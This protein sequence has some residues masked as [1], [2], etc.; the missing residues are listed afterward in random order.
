MHA[1]KSLMK[2]LFY[3]MNVYEHDNHDTD[4]DIVLVILKNSII[5][6]L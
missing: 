1:P 6:T 3:K 4:D 2:I 5:V